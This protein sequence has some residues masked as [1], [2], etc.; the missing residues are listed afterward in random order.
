MDTTQLSVKVVADV[1]DFRSKM[2]QVAEVTT[3][4]GEK[5]KQV[6]EKLTTYGT[7]VSGSVAAVAGAYMSMGNTIADGSERV[8]MSIE[9]YQRWDSVLKSHGTTMED[10]EGDLIA[11]AE[12]MNE[13][14]MGSGDLAEACD[15]LGLSVTKADGSLKSVNDFFPEFM[16]ALAG[17]ENETVKQ[18]IATAL[19]ST[20]GEQLLPVLGSE[21]ELMDALASATPIDEEKIRKAEE[22]NTK[23]EKLKD[24]FGDVVM[25]IGSALIPVLEPLLE[26][27]GKIAGKLAEW[28]D[29]NPILSGTIVSIVAVLGG[30]MAVLGPIISLIGSLATIAGS[31]NVAMLPIAGTTAAVIAGITA[32]IA[33]GVLLYKNWDTIKEKASECWNK[34]KEVISNI[35]E[36]T[37]EVIENI[38]ESIKEFL[39]GLWEGIKELASTIFNG[40]KDLIT[41]IWET[42]K[43]V[44]STIWNGIKDLCSTIWNGIKDIASTIFNGIKDLISN[45]WEG[46]K[47]ITLTI[48][49]TIKNTC[50]TIWNGIKE[51]ASSIFNGIKDLISN[52]WEGIKTITTNAW[53]TIKNF[54]IN[55]VNGIKDGVSVGLNG[56]K[57]IFSNVWNGIKETVSNVW[58]GITGIVSK[59]VE[60]LKGF[61]NFKWELPK[62]KLPHFS[63]TGKF[64][65]NPPSVPKFGIDW[66]SEGGIFTR[67]SILG[68]VGVGDA[69]NGVGHGAE[70]VLPIDRLPDLL[71]LNDRQG[72]VTINF[73]GKYSFRDRE[74]ID[75]FMKKAAY[76]IKRNY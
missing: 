18:S 67:K 1:D 48:W 39:S 42:I 2:D 46:I 20:T 3:Q 29:K 62:L 30:L 12:R 50:S 17:V 35:C 45:V 43:T 21:K 74:D 7:V 47:T 34:T 41:G 72:N 26:A 51:I 57:D 64:S 38:W 8:N 69:N 68:G 60:K 4:F 25:E 16:T 66:Y 63:I 10:A 36:A 53:N 14:S 15:Y 6:G 5:T 13:A 52:I 31:L 28:I 9:N 24:T 22:F 71:G 55:A 54:I 59:G 56:I 37:G 58:N 27:V 65:L 70:A 75:Y 44:T 76:E 23:F 19:L 73:N 11:F 49:N 40:I 33:V 32:L 61:M